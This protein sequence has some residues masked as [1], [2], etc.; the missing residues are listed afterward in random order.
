[1]YVGCLGL[2]LAVLVQFL[3]N[4]CVAAPNREKFTKTAYF[5]G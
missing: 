3:V 1:M 5:E 4:V 2:S